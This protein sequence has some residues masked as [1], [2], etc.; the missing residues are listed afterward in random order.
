MLFRSRHGQTQWN[1]E[2]RFQG[3]LDSPLT[4]EGVARALS[5]KEELSTIC[6]DLVYV[7]QSPRAIKTAHL[8]VG[9]KYKNLRLDKRLM[10]MRLGAWQGMTHDDVEKTYP[11]A[12]RAFYES[13]GSFIL[14]DSETYA[15]IFERVASFGQNL[16]K[17]DNKSNVESNVLIVTHGITLMML[18]L[19]F[20]EKSIDA[21]VKESVSPNG[22]IHHYYFDDKLFVR[23]T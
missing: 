13:P 8:I 16:I 6:F 18:K 9:E 11:D 2:K 10:E 5:L 12:L 7:S 20:E 17:H 1:K 14:E 4:E 19:F 21:I 22:V 3:W 23:K 15:Q